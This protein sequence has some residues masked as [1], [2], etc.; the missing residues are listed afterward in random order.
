MN[1]KWFSIMNIMER[2]FHFSFPPILSDI[3]NITEYVEV[4]RIDGSL[5]CL[6]RKKT[7]LA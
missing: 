2:N 4:F 6:S 7:H 3:Y 5:Y 1:E